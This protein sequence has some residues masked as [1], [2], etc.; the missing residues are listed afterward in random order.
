ML[1]KTLALGFVFFVLGTGDE[2][3]WLFDRFPKAQ[4]EKTYGFTVSDEFLRHLERAS[5]RF[6]NGGSG[7]I[8]SATVCCSPITTS[9]RAASR[10]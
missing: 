1:V 4:V 9:V 10:S 7:S 2:G 6:D 3:M 8:V 5:V